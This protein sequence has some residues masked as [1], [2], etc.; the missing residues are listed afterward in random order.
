MGIRLMLLHWQHEL[1]PRLRS[2]SALNILRSK[3]KRWRDLKR[4]LD[5]RAVV[6]GSLSVGVVQHLKCLLGTQKSQYLRW[7]KE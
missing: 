7:T 1:L 3:K 5:K 4:L 2:G 6:S